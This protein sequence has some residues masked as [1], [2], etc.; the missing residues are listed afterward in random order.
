MAF[1][2]LVVRQTALSVARRS[3]GRGYAKKVDIKALKRLREL[4]PV[5]M[6][7]AKE[8]LLNNNNDIDKAMVWLEEDAI[9]AG[10]KKAEKVKDRVA[11]EGAIAIYLNE[12]QSA[13]AIVELGC[14]TDFVARNGTFIDLASAIARQGSEGFATAGVLADIE[15]SQLAGKLLAERSVADTITETIGKLGE[16]IILRRAAA[17]GAEGAED[18]LVVSGYVHG[19]VAGSAGASA[20]KIGGLVAMRSS[21][22]LKGDDNRATI[23]QLGRRLAQQVVGY[24]PRYRTMAE[25]DAAKAQGLVSAEESPEVL[26][27]EAQQF[28]FGGGTVSEVLAKVSKGVGTPVV[29][30]SFVRFERGEGIEKPEKPDFAE[31]VRQQL[32]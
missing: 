15:V 12:K 21:G 20:G 8:A 19:A 28:L 11:S 22:P 13:G 6:S 16:N 18:S 32:A 5:S 23:N 14:E 26:V 17:V 29:I 31:E 30:E 7:K 3:M 4:N 2:R 24:A 25:W 1:A 27:L 10:A 9:K